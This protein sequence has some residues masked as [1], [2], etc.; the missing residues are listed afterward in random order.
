MHTSFGQKYREQFYTKSGT[1]ATLYC[2]VLETL[3][4]FWTKAGLAP[5]PQIPPLECNLLRDFSLLSLLLRSTPGRLNENGLLNT[6]LIFQT[7][8]LFVNYLSRTSRWT[9]I[10]S[11]QHST[12][13]QHGVAEPWK[14]WCH[15]YF[16]YQF[17]ICFLKINWHRIR[18]YWKMFISLS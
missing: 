6:F 4:Q 13:L 8:K 14:Y 1:L 10:Q 12:F 18:E 9:L 17:S 16:F 11:N 15:S 7:S 5:P 2:L 3:S